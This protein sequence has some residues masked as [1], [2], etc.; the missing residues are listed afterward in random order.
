MKIE[1]NRSS[2]VPLAQQIH[3][4][5]ADRILS[6]YFP[7]GSRL[8][9]VR[10]LT[11]MLKVS[12]VTVSH[13]LD[14]LEAN[15]LITR[16]QGKGTFV[17]EERPKED[18]PDDDNH[19]LP[20]PDYLHRSQSMHYSQ[21]PAAINF[22]LSAVAADLLPT[23]ELAESLRH[24][25]RYYPEVLAQY[26]EIQGDL[27]LRQAFATYLT[28]ERISVSP[29]EILV[30]NGSQQGIDLVARSF[31]GPGD[32]VVTEEP[33]YA[34]AID[35]FRSRGATILSVPMD[36]EGMRIDRL[37]ALADQAVPKLIY[38]VPSFQSPTGKVMSLRRRK[39]L[40]ELAEDL[41]CLVLEDDPWSEIYYDAVPPPHIKSMDRH[42]HVIYLK[43]LSKMLSPGC[44]IGFLIASV[45][46]LNRL[47]T[48]KTNAD[49]GNPLLNQKV[50]LPIF[51]ANQ[52]TRL[53]QQLR[54]AL[55]QRR[56][57]ALEL[58]KRHAP[59]GVRWVIPRGGFNLW[60]TLPPQA[61]TNELL[62]E[63]EARHLTF[64]PGSA[65]YP[66]DLEWNH[67]RIS[68]SQVS[69]EQLRHGITELCSVIASYLADSGT[70]KGTTPLF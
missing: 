55:K 56:D 52:I 41:N 11:R 39:Q 2:Q 68:F 14:L 7:K 70:R 32:I 64:L 15:K 67:L 20:F 50:I 38:T 59:K 28:N 24:L 25:A 49:L 21:K 1:L 10:Q 63:A 43:G 3:Q 35:V 57:L 66:N 45:A 9:S 37:T 61:N 34:A 13:A 62:D 54:T 12:P 23:Q 6:G 42:G 18:K 36:E 4:A 40:L 44:R 16:I 19:P 8:P 69:E 60:L 58:L 47:I 46:I 65:C 5:L 30:T 27:E 48:A 29:Q 22:S 33:T 31:I 26:G 17:Y 53:L 51:E